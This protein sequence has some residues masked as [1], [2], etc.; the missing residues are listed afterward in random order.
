[1]S[2]ASRPAGVL[3]LNFGFVYTRKKVTF[4][5]GNHFDEISVL[6]AAANFREG[7]AFVEL[8]VVD[9]RRLWLGPFPSRTNNSPNLRDPGAGAYQLSAQFPYISKSA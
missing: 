8:S 1:V 5:V 9:W 6:V 4:V 7:L 3:R 2:S